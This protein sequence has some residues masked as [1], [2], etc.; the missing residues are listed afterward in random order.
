MFQKPLDGYADFF[1]AAFVVVAAGIAAGFGRSAARNWSRGSALMT[2][3]FSI[4]P[5]RA[6]ATPY[7]MKRRCVV[8]CESVEIVIFTPRSFAM[9]RWTS[10]KSRR[11][12]DRKST[13]LN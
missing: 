5:R 8:E 9:R 1:L 7:P 4:Q 3:F 6:V 13:R 11:S 12:G 10:F 2:S